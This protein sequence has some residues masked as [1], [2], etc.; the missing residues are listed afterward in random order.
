MGR[1]P[2]DGRGRLGG[3]TAGTKNKPKP[4]PLNGW[5]VETLYTHRDTIEQVLNDTNPDERFNRAG[6]LSTLALADALNRAAAAI[7]A[8]RTLPPTITAQEPSAAAL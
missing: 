5:L 2:N 8:A 6:L 4:Q 3:R 1:K 7:T